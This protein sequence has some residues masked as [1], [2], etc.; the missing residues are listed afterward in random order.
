MILDF[1]NNHEKIDLSA[2]GLD[3]DDLDIH[4]DAGN[5]VISNPV[6]GSSITVIGAGWPDPRIGLHLRL[7]APRLSA[8]V[9]DDLIAFTRR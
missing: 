4:K 8:S 9:A 6:D 1:E 3:F 7:G 5:A 2:T